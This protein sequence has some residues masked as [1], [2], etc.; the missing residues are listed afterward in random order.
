[1]YT[2]YKF[3]KTWWKGAVLV[4]AVWLI[5]L[6]VQSA[7]QKRLSRSASN[8]VQLIFLLAALAGLYFSFTDFRDSISHRW[9]GTRFH[10]GVYL[11]WFGW[12]VISVYLL[13]KKRDV[14]E[15]NSLQTRL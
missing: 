9:L 7:V 3:L 8:I 14:N 10:N 11:F 1:M 5:L 15:L 12:I 2:E 13:I 6:M 4:F